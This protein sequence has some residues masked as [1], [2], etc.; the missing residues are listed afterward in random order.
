MKYDKEYFKDKV[1]V[2]RTQEQLDKLLN[3]FECDKSDINVKEFPMIVYEG[4]F[5]GI[6]ISHIS[7]GN[8]V[9]LKY[10]TDFSRTIEEFK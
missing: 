4:R 5:K 1:L 9:Q 7:I 10:D 2:I 8:L 3:D 6:D